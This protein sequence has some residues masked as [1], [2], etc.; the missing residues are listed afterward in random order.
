MGLV[1]V[2]RCA[3]AC[4]LPDLAIGDW[5][6]ENGVDYLFFSVWPVP[7]PASGF[8]RPTPPRLTWNRGLVIANNIPGSTYL[9][10]WNLRT[11]KAQTVEP[12]TALTAARSIM[13]W[14]SGRPQLQVATGSCL[15]KHN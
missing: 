14:A 6:L 12:S 11:G 4:F 2:Q 9:L 5:R 13:I 8:Q 7:I 10:W 1:Q 15:P 3:S